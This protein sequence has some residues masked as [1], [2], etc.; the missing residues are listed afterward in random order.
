[1]AE[2]RDI[3]FIADSGDDFENLPEKEEVELQE[4]ISVL[5]LQSAII[6]TN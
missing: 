6:V 5:P 1:M 2:G 3:L 4:Q